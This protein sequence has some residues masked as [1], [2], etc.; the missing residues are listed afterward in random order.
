[1]WG[2]SFNDL[3]KKAAEM[4]E[5]AAASIV[6]LNNLL[7]ID[8]CF[9][10]NCIYL[11]VGRRFFTHSLCN[12]HRSLSAMTH[13]NDSNRHLQQLPLSAWDR[14]STW[15][16][17]SSK[18]R[19]HP[20]KRHRKYQKLALPH[21][22]IHH[23]PCKK[24]RGRQN[25]QRKSN[26]NRHHPLSCPIWAC[27][28]WA[29]IWIWTCHQCH[30]SLPLPAM[31]H[32]NNKRRSPLLEEAPREISFLRRQ[33]LRNHCLLPPQR[34]SSLFLQKLKFLHNW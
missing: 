26:K 14:C 29:W 25:Y 28:I 21:F 15:T 2:A 8:S 24:S 31:Q 6:R 19:Q 16:P 12:I 4:Q 9:V 10:W 22:T 17:S 23:N 20:A 13:A 1:M 3:A 7:P 30:H 32:R 5:Q 27:Q 11:F 18:K 34:A 33:P